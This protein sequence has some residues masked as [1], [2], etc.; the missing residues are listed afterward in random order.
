[1][2]IRYILFTVCVLC[3]QVL[4]AQGIHIKGKIT[5][6]ETHAIVDGASII[7]LQSGTSSI[8]DAYG[9]SIILKR[10][11]DTIV[12]SH[13]GYNA[14]RI[15][16]ADA[17]INY[18]ISL[19]PA[20]SELKDVTINTGYQQLKPNETNGS[21]VVVDNKTLNLQSGLNI[22]Q[23]LN[24]VTSSVLFNTIVGKN[25]PNPQNTTGITIRG[26]STINGPLDPLIVVDNFIYDG[27]INNINPNDVESVTVLKDAAATSI[28]GARAGNGVI[29]IT[30]KRGKF[31]QK[32][33]V[34][35][36]A[37]IIVTNKPDL[38]QL[39]QMSS[40]DFIDVEQTLFNKG[41]YDDAINDFSLPALTPAVEVFLA[42]RNGQISAADSTTQINALKKIDSRDQFNKYFYREG[43]TQQYAVN[44]RGGSEN[45]AWLVSGNY[46]KD[47]SN[48]KA[49]YH[50]ENFHFENTYRPVKNLNINLGVY[51][52]NS[53]NTSGEPD[54]NGVAAINGSYRVPYLQFADEQGNALAVTH[55]NRVGYIDTVGEGQLLNWQYYP[56]EDWKHYVTRTNTEDILA[57][58]GIQYHL[59]KGLGIDLKYQY[60]KQNITGKT[61]ADT[62][63]FY[64]RNE[65]NLFTQ[66]NPQTGQVTYV[67]PMGGILTQSSSNLFSHNVR[68]QL[69]FDRT[70]N[71]I[72]RVIALAGMEI[73]ET[74]N[75]GTTNV[76]Y[77]YNE[78][79]LRVAN[80]DLVNSYPTFITGGLQQ[81]QGTYG[82]SETNYRFASFF[83]N[84]SYIYKKRYILSGSMR[85][86]G[87]NIFGANTN[88][89][90]KPLWSAGIGWV[91]S[92]EK[93]YHVDWLPYLKF[94]GTFG[95]SG[96]VDLTRSASAVGGSGTD[97]TT[98]LPFIRIS[99]PN[100]PEL[101]WEQ[102]YQSNFR[103]EF[104][105][106][107]NFLTGS[108]E[109][110]H[111]KGTNLYGESPYDYTAW[112][113]ALTIEKNVADMVGNGIDLDLNSQLINKVF[114]W[115]LGLLLNYNQSK[116]T[117]YY[118]QNPET[119]AS[120]LGDGTLINP[121]AGKPLYAIVA[122]RWGGLDAEGNPQGYIGNNK[123]TNYEALAT[124]AINYGLDSNTIVYKGSASPTWF[125]S[126]MNTFS[127]K[128]LTV[129]IN[130][131][132]QFGYYALKPSLSYTAL[133][134]SGMGNS[135]YENRW[136]QQG[137]ENKTNVPA[138]TF[139]ADD[140]RDAFYQ[141]SEIN[142]IRADNLRLQFINADYT[143]PLKNKNIQGFSVY[144]NA[145]NLGVLWRANKDHI[146][147]DYIGTLSPPK[148]FT[149]GV[150]ASF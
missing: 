122:Y 74:G 16:I 75:S 88:D 149:I 2:L 127:W 133:F 69:N 11:P 92:K 54:Y 61:L 70:F 112:G 43:L 99:T 48:L 123:S 37:D 146:D 32:M 45:L 28:W 65:I 148:T 73:K 76:Y 20:T 35:F 150:R 94:T 107:N 1:M 4:S 117:K 8:S 59:L 44:L 147:P 13:I 139:P 80:V 33:Q 23:R 40:S 144:F 114:K 91:T 21:F 109:Y 27:D 131:T 62:A 100:N 31:N 135:E 68:G 53:T 126:F 132:G 110:Y 95:Y 124:S 7:S 128:R 102:A 93:F 3:V 78:D 77:G 104:S 145:A 85:R 97:R 18:N 5:D 86:D 105:S 41:F 57:N 142:V 22:L 39:P 118:N 24:G 52:T 134:N 50:K 79:P 108:V 81:L 87:S 136:Q 138:M 103:F 121:V 116:T 98:G 129:T 17:A 101:Q 120:L 34:D 56:L 66:I 84:A 89:K 82:L 15:S 49:K 115:N 130:I 58:V 55:Y 137:D 143:I 67:V 30:T 14:R 6:A 47:I 90:W 26:L 25:N 71:N 9:F 72:H 113:R 119:I 106:I 19:E 125:G 141:E 111:K 12:I 83:A 140:R 46:D 36:N 96:N 64:A 42:R 60:E 38:Y 29:V 10:L 51:Y 63:S